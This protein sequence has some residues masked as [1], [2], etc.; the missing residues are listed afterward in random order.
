MKSNKDTFSERLNNDDRGVIDEIY[1][2]YHARLFRFAFAYL[3]NEDDAY[4]IVQE[5]FIKL[6]ENRL[7][8]KNTNFDAFLFT[9][10]KN[11]VLSVFRKKATEQK[12]LSE[13]VVCEEDDPDKIENELDYTLL[14]NRINNLVDKLPP[15][16]KEVF[17]LSRENGLSNKEIAI[18]KGISEKTV[19]DHLTK[20]LN[21]LRQHFDTI[22]FSPLLFIC[23]FL[24]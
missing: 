19:E 7:Q 6:W 3:K 23:L 16:R 15:K 8:L 10:T 24:E 13:C 14:K 22:G 5:V 17:L 18:A 2:F 1:E 9:V 11:A 4:D 21:F 12:Y 20:S